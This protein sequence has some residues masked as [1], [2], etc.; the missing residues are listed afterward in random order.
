MDQLRYMGRLLDFE[1]DGY[2]NL[3]WLQSYLNNYDVG[4]TALWYDTYGR[5]KELSPQC[6]ELLL[7][8]MWEGVER[9][10]EELFELR[11]TQEGFCCTFNYVRSDTAFHFDRRSEEAI[12][13]RFYGTENGLQL[14]LNASDSDYYYPLLN[15]YGHSALIFQAHDFPDQATGYLEQRFIKPN[16]ETMIE[17][18]ASTLE[19]KESL[20]WFRPEQRECLF[21]DERPGYN[22]FYSQS[23]CLLNCRIRSFVALCDCVPFFIPRTTRNSLL[24]NNT[25]TCNLEHVSCLNK[26]QSE[27]NS[28][29]YNNT[30][31]TRKALRSSKK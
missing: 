17:L 7:H 30:E 8:C 3:V 22:G 6:D 23:E 31:H 13:T 19:A 18:F 11:A 16:V 29:V 24:S 1:V 20:R 25:Q 27:C 26:Y 28:A 5:M 15:N 12:K 9:N 21:R 4:E 2:D 14:I 10:C